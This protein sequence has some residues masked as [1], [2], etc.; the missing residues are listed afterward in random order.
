[1]SNVK[2]VLYELEYLADNVPNRKKEDIEKDL[3]EIIKM[4]DKFIGDIQGKV[5]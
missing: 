1:M 5:F 3:R 2:N 4:L